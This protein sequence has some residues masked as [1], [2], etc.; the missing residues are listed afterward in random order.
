MLPE[1]KLKDLFHLWFNY[2]T[3]AYHQALIKVCIEILAKEFTELVTNE[4]WEKE[5]LD[6][7]RDQLIEFLRSSD[8]VVPNEFFVWESVL[9]WLNAPSHVERRGNTCAPLLVQILPLLRFFWFLN[10]LIKYFQISLHDRR[11]ASQNWN[12][13]DENCEAAR[14]AVPTTHPH[15]FQIHFTPIGQSGH[16]YQVI[17]DFNFFIFFYN[18][19]IFN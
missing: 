5:W 16:A 14:E 8:L 12:G 10:N 2:S 18:Y 15:G 1:L 9:K 3:K 17:F 19:K 6:L 13:W 11:T 7:D 4:D